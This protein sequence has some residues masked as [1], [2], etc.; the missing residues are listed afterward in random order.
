MMTGTKRWLKKT[1][2]YYAPNGYSDD[3]NVSYSATPTS[4]SCHVRSEVIREMVGD[5]VEVFTKPV[6]VFDEDADIDVEGKI[7]FQDGS[8]FIIRSVN[9]VYGPD[10]N[11]YFIEVRG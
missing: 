10:G 1:V 6:L 11:T 5:R 4:L 9:E 2:E 8:T 3:G 7:V